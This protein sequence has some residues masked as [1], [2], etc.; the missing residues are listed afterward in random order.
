MQ[1]TVLAMT[2]GLTVIAGAAQAQ[3]ATNP[4][5]VEQV[6]STSLPS[7][8]LV[9]FLAAIIVIGIATS[10]GSTLPR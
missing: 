8:L 3:T 9:P 5:T 6:T 7:G 4:A 1:K 10:G 2:L